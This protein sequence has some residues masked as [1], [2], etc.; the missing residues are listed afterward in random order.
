MVRTQ[1]FQPSGQNGSPHLV[2]LSLA[3][4]QPNSQTCEAVT[5]KLPIDTVVTV[6]ILHH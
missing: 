4:P 3:Y 2:F 6:T 1:V 5:K